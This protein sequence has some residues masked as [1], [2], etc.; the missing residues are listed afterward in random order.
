MDKTV[1]VF[2]D[3]RGGDSGQ[4]FENAAVYPGESGGQAMWR[5][6]SYGYVFLVVKLLY[7]S[8]CVSVCPSVRPK[9]N[10]G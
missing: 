7:N 9:S 10:G 2:L 6:Q 3:W 8:L 5:L 4:R 1:L